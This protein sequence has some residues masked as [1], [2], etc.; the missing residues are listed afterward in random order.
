G[1]PPGTHPAP[2]AI[3]ACWS[4]GAPITAHDFVY[5]WRRFVDPRTAAPMA[6]Q[7]FYV[8][9]AEDINTRKRHPHE[10]GVRALDEFTFQVD[11]R[12]PTPFFLQ[13]ITVYWFSA[14]PRRAIDTARQRGNESSWTEPQHMVVSGP[15]TLREWRMHEGITTVRNPRYYDAHMV[16]L[17]EFTFLPLVDGTTAVN[18][19]QSGA[20]ATMPGFSFPPVFTSILGRK[21]D[22]HAEPAFGTVAPT[23][24]ALKPP[25]DNVLLRYAL[26]M[27]AEK[28]P[29][30]DLLGGSRI[31][32]SNLV[33]P[34]PD[35]PRPDTLQVTVDGTSYDVLS[36]NLEGA[37][38]LPAKA[39][40]DSVS[41]HARRTLEITYHFPALPDANLKAHML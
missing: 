7:L 3:P 26:N 21:K 30:T 27:G 13:V 19:Y 1:V 32:A 17:D 24:S 22:F 2:D 37:R 15:F 11:L 5:S 10:L 40:F 12:S 18:L 31:P 36:F 20:V 8:K 4:A 35:Y 39:G 23:I 25:L 33:P 41:G 28:K 16:G 9:N 29:F 38:A 14:V 6:Y 34:V